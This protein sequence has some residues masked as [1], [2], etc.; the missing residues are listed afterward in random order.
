MGYGCV[1]V[2]SE[3]DSDD[4]FSVSAPLAEVVGGQTG[5]ESGRLV[6][7]KRSDDRGGEQY[8]EDEGCG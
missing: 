2:F 8:E 4:L 3:T 5:Q 1:L 7:R 6:P